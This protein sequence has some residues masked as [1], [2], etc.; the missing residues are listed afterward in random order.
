LAAMT[1]P[2]V[3]VMTAVISARRRRGAK[4]LAVDV[5]ELLPKRFNWHDVLRVQL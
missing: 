4:V 5:H 1:G 2:G 3:P